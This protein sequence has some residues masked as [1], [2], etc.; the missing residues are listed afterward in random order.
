MIDRPVTRGL[1]LLLA[2]ALLAP[3]A[4]A[5]YE[6]GSLDVVDRG[7]VSGDL[8]LT[9]GDSRYS[10]EVAPGGT[11]TVTFPVSPPTGASIRNASVYLFWTWSHAGTTGVPPDLRV[12]SGGAPLSPTH[13]YADRK[14]SPPYD[15]PSGLFTYD[16]AGQVHAGA[17]LALTV[18]NA[19]S[20]A[21]VAFSGAVLL[22]TFDGGGRDV[23]YW[24]AEGADMLYATEG[25]TAEEATARIAYSDL[26]AVL[27]GGHATLL[28][29]VPGGNKGKN[30]LAVNGRMF[31][32]IFDGKPYADLAV[33]STEIGP[34]L[35]PGSNTVTL[36]DEGDYMVP[37]L[38][39]LTIRDSGGPS[40]DATTRSAPSPGVAALIG[41]AFAAVVA[42]RSGRRCE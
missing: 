40:A 31:P 38:F 17:P 25:I 28:S 6:G 21:G 16:V 22:Y 37:G 32:G 3:A 18:T 27:A 9:R 13:A 2:V 7:Q 30:T 26:P 11:Y 23:A 14:G 1:L 20:G 35:V 15:Y 29:V 41:T 5:G 39:V 10:G 34:W 36:S 42:L 24:V 4:L 8:V 12:E 33:N 19:A